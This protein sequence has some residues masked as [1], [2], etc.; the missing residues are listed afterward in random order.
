MIEYSSKE[1]IQEWHSHCIRIGSIKMTLRFVTLQCIFALVW[2]LAH[3]K[4]THVLKQDLRNV[5]QG[6]LE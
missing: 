4:C 3:T 5:A 1:F 2:S 6:H